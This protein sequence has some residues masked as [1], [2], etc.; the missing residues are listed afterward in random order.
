M[1]RVITRLSAGGGTL[2]LEQGATRRDAGMRC[3]VG[4]G[5]DFA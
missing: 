4:I 1:R 2:V 3:D 5:R